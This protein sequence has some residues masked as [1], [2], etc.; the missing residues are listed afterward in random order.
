[1]WQKRTIGSRLVFWDADWTIFPEDI[2]GVKKFCLGVQIFYN[3]GN[4]QRQTAKRHAR[5]VK[6]L[7]LR[8]VP[9]APVSRKPRPRCPLWPVVPL[10]TVNRRLKTNMQ[11]KTFI[12]WV[13]IG[14]KGKTEAKL[15]KTPFISKELRGR[16]H[17]LQNSLSKLFKTHF[18][19]RS[20][21]GWHAWSK[22][23]ILCVFNDSSTQ[24]QW[25]FIKKAIII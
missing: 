2:T 25:F 17:F 20:T 21:L 4:R 22:S 15:K 24:K 18:F 13:H 9:S 12:A 19:I 23:Q 10:T 16:P 11:R 7:A 1:V 5:V 8:P 14:L 3:T 6:R